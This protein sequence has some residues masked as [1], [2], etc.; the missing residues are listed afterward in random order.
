MR[1]EHAVTHPWSRVWRGSPPHARG[2]LLSGGPEYSPSRITPACAGSTTGGVRTPSLRKD[3][4][5]MR[6]EH[7]VGEFGAEGGRGSPP[8]A[9]GALVMMVP[10]PFRTGITPACAGSTLI[11]HSYPSLAADHPRMRGEPSPAEPKPG[12]TMGSPPHARGAPRSPPRRRGN[13]PDHPRMRGEHTRSRVSVSVAGGSPPHARGARSGLRSHADY[14]R[15][16][17]ACA[18]STGHGLRRGRCGWDHPRMRGEHSFHPLM[19]L[20][21]S[22][23]PP[24]ARGARSF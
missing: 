3:H 5:R 7:E 1:G 16:T 18:G 10:L 24:H 12:R 14:R 4:P 21:P 22:G 15:I 9:R 2:A 20:T 8:H 13:P 11:R 19:Y 23:S 17:P 6:G